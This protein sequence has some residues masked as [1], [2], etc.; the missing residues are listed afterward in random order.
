MRYVVHGEEPSGVFANAS[1]LVCVT[2]SLSDYP[3]LLTKPIP[4]G[5]FALARP[6]RQPGTSVWKFA[7]ARPQ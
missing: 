1:C 7:Q 6:C 2:M 3:Q 5:G 4:R